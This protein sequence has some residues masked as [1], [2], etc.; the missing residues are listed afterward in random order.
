MQ[1][2][3]ENFPFCTIEPNTAKVAVPDKR[4][5]F[6]CSVYHPKSEVQASLTV[7][8]IAGLVRGASTGQGLGNEFLS[9]VKAVDGLYHVC[10]GFED[11]EVT[12]VEPGPI[13]PVRDLD[14]IHNE[15]VQKDIQQVDKWITANE[16]NIVDRKLGGKE[17]LFE[18]ETLKKVQDGLKEGKVRCFL[19]FVFVACD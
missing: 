13:D 17:A 12:H 14:I 10:R 8:D 11:S 3:A 19:F 9:H 18:Y 2:P 16:K 7:N 5:N 15:L 4:F 6:L 1:V